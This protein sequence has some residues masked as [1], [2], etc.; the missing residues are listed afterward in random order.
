LISE[1]IW[2]AVGTPSV[3]SCVWSVPE[4]V[5]VELQSMVHSTGLCCGA[6]PKRV[7]VSLA[8]RARVRWRRAQRYCIF[9]ARAS[10]ESRG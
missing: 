9:S 8:A 5:S 2:P 3:L 6:R 10:R 4:V 7:E 1:I